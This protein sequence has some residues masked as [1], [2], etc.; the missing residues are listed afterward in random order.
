MTR[1]PTRLL[2]FEPNAGNTGLLHATVTE[3]GAA[4]FAALASLKSNSSE[5][6][7]QP[8]LMMLDLNLPKKSG[9]EALAAIKADTDLKNIPVVVFSSSSAPGDVSS[10]YA[11]H[12]NY[13]VAK[14]ARS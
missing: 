7:W 14:P 5:N 2:L 13:Y 4:S 1:A 8:D 10:A 9:H 11:L 12:A 3:S 6:A